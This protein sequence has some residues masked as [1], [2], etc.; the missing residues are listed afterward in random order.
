MDSNSR[1]RISDRGLLGH[2]V[3]PLGLLLQKLDVGGGEPGWLDGRSP[4][5]SIGHE[6][7]LAA[8]ML[9]P[10]APAPAPRDRARA[11]RLVA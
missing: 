5:R 4:R 2:T 8:V 11:R 7:G 1:F 3:I 6:I 10:L 9:D